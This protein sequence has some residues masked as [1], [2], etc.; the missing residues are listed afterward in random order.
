MNH[1]KPQRNQLNNWR[2]TV[3]L[4]G[5]SR[6]LMRSGSQTLLVAAFKKRNATSEIGTTGR[7]DRNIRVY[8]FQ[9]VEFAPCRNSTN[10]MQ[11]RAVS[12][13]GSHVWLTRQRSGRHISIINPSYGIRVMQIT[14]SQLQR[15]WAG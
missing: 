4:S 6:F 8:E 1:R 14:A 9:V 2:M 10:N 12:V 7:G 11:F 13:T 3:V 5:K 15:G